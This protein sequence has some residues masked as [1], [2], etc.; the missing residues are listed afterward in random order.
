MRVLWLKYGEILPADTGGKLRSFHLLRHLSRQVELTF[1]SYSQAPFTPGYAEQLAAELPDSQAWEIRDIPRWREV[2]VRPL[3]LSALRGLPLN[4]SRFTS[5]DARARLAELGRQRQFDIGICDFLTPTAVYPADPAYP[6]V[7][8]EHNVEW[9]LWQRRTATIARGPKRLLYEWE[10]HHTRTH[11][12]AML[13]RFDVTLAVSALDREGLLE[14]APAADV[15]VIE[16]GVD[17]AG[18]AP[19]A[20]NARSDVLVVFVGSMDWHPNEDGV[21]WFASEIW[22]RVLAAIPGARFRVVGRRPP[23]SILALAEQGIEIA[24]DVD[25]VVPHLHE[26]AVM[27]VPLRAGGGTRLKIFEAMAA[28]AAIVSTT[29]G[30]EGLQVTHERDILLADDAECFA[31]ALVALLRDDLRR[32]HVAAAA[33]ETVGRFDWAAVASSLRGMLAGTVEHWSKAPRAS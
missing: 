15:R 6:S 16:T 9:R 23:P 31:D 26:A 21:L 4:V 3:M 24:A 14:L 25:S 20:L 28:G 10:T 11:E 2:G 32:A 18:F 19:A 12:A 27:V 17:V 7:L 22:H 1:V 30:A 8:F 13:N 5:L 33:A 29:V